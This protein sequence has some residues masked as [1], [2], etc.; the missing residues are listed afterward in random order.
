M[1]HGTQNTAAFLPQEIGV[2]NDLGTIVTT[3]CE[4]RGGGEI[5][6]EIKG[7]IAKKVVTDEEMIA[8]TTGQGITG[9]TNSAHAHHTKTIKDTA[10]NDQKTPLAMKG[11]ETVDQKRYRLISFL[12]IFRVL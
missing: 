6:G 5:G 11:A 12:R 1:T 9:R 4:I 10:R 7:K 2:M 8:G 3:E